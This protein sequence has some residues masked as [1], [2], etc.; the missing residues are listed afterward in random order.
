MLFPFLHLSTK[1]ESYHEMKEETTES[2]LSRHEKTR[3]KVAAEMIE[4]TK[5]LKYI[6]K[7]ARNIIRGDKQVVK[8][9]IN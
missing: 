3:E 8:V 9:I 7:T 2:L 4:M 6:S 5:S 1:S